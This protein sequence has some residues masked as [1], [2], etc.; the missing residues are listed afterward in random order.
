MTPGRFDMAV[1]RNQLAKITIDFV[2]YDFSSATFAMQV[3]LYRGVTGTPL[4]N[5]VNAAAGAEGISAG[6]VT[7]GGVPTTSVTIQLAEAT[8]DAAVP[9]PANG[10][11]PGTD[12]R[13]KYDLQITPAGGTKQ[14]W[15]E[16]D[17]MIIEGVTI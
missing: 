15:L 5:L 9:W 1:Y 3:R 11:E 2:G 16:G 14:R 17:F 13:L 10:L 4:F 7:T 8:I 6:V 12:V